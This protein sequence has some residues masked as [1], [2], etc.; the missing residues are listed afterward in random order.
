MEAL[1]GLPAAVAPATRDAAVGAVRAV[2]ATG[3][4]LPALLAAAKD[5]IVPTVR[6]FA[7]QSVG[8][9]AASG[10]AGP[11]SG[12]PPPP[13]AAAID[14]LVASLGAQLGPLLG[15]GPAAT[16]GGAAGVVARDPAAVAFLEVLREEDI[17]RGG[18]A[19]GGPSSSSAAAA[20]AATATEAAGTATAP[21]A[22]TGP[23]VVPPALL[24]PGSTGPSVAALQRALS[25]V[26]VLVAR[27]VAAPGA[28]GHYGPATTGAV[29]RLQRDFELDVLVPGVYDDL[30]AASLNSLIEAGVPVAMAAGVSGAGGEVGAAASSSTT[31]E[32]V[33][34]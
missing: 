18:A 9:P 16:V 27:D 19:D 30:T 6:S 20:P 31:G 25:A 10:A 29:A 2:M 11:S 33:D 14:A 34:M 28:A 13:S 5:I 1:R 3:V 4:G 8:V 22:A 23:L 26:G 32:D 12:A 21:A 17:V 24:Q 7:A 15:D